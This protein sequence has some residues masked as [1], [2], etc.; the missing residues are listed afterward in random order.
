MPLVQ[1]LAPQALALQ[2][3]V[4]QVRVPLLVPVLQLALQE[5]ETAPRSA[6]YPRWKAGKG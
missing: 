3:L 2:V 5:R 6:L 4:Q 1:A